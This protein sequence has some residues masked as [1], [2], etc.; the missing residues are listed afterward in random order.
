[1]ATLIPDTGLGGGAGGT[2]GTGA[3]P[4]EVFTGTAKNLVV[5]D[6]FKFFVLTNVSAITITI[7][8]NAT[9]AFSIS[10]EMGFTRDDAGSVTFV[11][12]GGVLL[13]S[14]D[15]LVTINA[16]HSTATLKKID[17][18]HWVLIGDLA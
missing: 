17:T 18:D 16:Q 1:M 7:P 9:E 11:A 5:S 10:A 3:F 8:L 13:D 14:R 15:A 6:N 12:S 2:G 4:V